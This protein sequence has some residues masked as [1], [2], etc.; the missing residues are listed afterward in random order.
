MFPFVNRVDDGKYRFNNEEYFL[1]INEPEQNNAIH[2]LVYNKEF[3]VDS[4]E[5]SSNE[6]IIS[7]TYIETKKQKGFPYKYQIELKYKLTATSLALSINVTNIDEKAFPFTIGWHPY[8][9]SSD[10]SKSTISFKSGKTIEMNDKSITE[11]VIDKKQDNQLILNHKNFDDCYGLASNVILFKTPDYSFELTSNEQNSYLQ[12][13]TPA[14][15][16]MVAIE[17]QTGISDS[18][19]NKEGLKFLD[20]DKKYN[21]TWQVNLINH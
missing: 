10:L 19:N 8:F 5:I 16:S 1:N 17:P 9:Y 7:L 13:Y 18:F 6:A 12:I 14:A 2:G 20:K 11:K 21:I 4:K 15:F 3:L